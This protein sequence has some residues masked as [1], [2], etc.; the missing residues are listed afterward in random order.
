MQA[1]H[2][3]TT[4]FIFNELIKVTTGLDAQQYLDRYIRKPM[5]MRYFRYGLTKRDQDT[6]GD[7]YL[8]RAGQCPDQ[9]RTHRNIGRSSGQGG[10]DDQ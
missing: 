1:Y 10:G 2:A 3:L 5:G 8:H 7:Q 4:G 9:P 6:C